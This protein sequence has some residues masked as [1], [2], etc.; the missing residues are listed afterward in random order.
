MAFKPGNKA[1]S[2]G[3]RAGAGRKPEWLTAKCK[4]IVEDKRL[5]DFLADVASGKK[6]DVHVTG[7][8]LVVKVPASIKDRR[9]AL[10]TLL[11]RGYGKPAQE[12]VHSGEVSGRFVLVCPE[13]GK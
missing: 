2:G 8:G 12:L 13:A 10:N 4:A 11:E 3:A 9:E 1:G 6:V 5:I 7:T